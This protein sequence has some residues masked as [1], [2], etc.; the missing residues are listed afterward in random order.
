MI[1][2]HQG[3]LLKIKQMLPSLPKQE[4][5]VGSYTLERPHETVGYSITKLASACGVSNTTVLRFCRRMGIEGYRQFRIALAKENP[6]RCLTI[7]QSQSRQRAR[8]G[9]WCRT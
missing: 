9:R 4:H 5:K 7:S 8:G 6:S 2:R 1:V 3:I